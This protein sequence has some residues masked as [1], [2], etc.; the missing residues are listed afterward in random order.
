MPA[1]IPRATRSSIT[2]LLPRTAIGK[3]QPLQ[4]RREERRQIRLESSR[5]IVPP[6]NPV[7]VKVVVQKTLHP[8]KARKERRIE[9]SQPRV[10]V[11][12]TAGIATSGVASIEEVVEE[13]AAAAAVLAP[14]AT[15]SSAV[16]LFGIESGHVHSFLSVSSQVSVSVEGL[17][18]SLLYHY[19]SI[20]S[21][22]R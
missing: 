2:Q 1:L 10:V 12:E 6:T 16:S 21:V 14:L 3:P 20:T 17:L 4:H 8:I 13:A 7:A 5:G 9:T 15:N 11:V 19:P 18:R 22:S